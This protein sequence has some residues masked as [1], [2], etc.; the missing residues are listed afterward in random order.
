MRP[1]DVTKHRAACEKWKSR[2]LTF[3]RRCDI[4]INTS[5]PNGYLHSFPRDR[6]SVRVVGFPGWRAHN[7]FTVVSAQM[8]AVLLS[9][10]ARLRAA[11]PRHSDAR[12]PA[13]EGGRGVGDSPTNKFE[14]RRN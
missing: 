3:A 9:K 12:A 6:R 13:L 14:E 5:E 7:T 1:R 11:L 10:A 8:T 2:V 4:I